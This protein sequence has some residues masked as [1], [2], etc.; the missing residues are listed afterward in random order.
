MLAIFSPRPVATPRV[1]G[2]ISTRARRTTRVVVARASS[3]PDGKGGVGAGAVGDAGVAVSGGDAVDAGAVEAVEDM[4]AVEAAEAVADEVA[5]Q[6]IVVVAL[7]W[8]R[9]TES[10]LDGDVL[11]WCGAAFV[12]FRVL[13]ILKPP[14]IDGLQSLPLGWGVLA[15][16]LAA[17]A[18]AAVAILAASAVF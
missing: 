10:R 5:G 7:P 17:G 4:E 8:W 16:D 9:F 6:A 3:S 12:L 11:L 1:G 18:L 14:P 15:D 13:D 2:R